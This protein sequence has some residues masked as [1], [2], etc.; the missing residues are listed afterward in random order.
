LSIIITE[1]GKL[2]LYKIYFY[3]DKNGVE[4]I[5]EYIA[6]LARKNDKDSSIKLSKIRD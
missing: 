1:E 4:P 2:R 5:A 3:K 6:E